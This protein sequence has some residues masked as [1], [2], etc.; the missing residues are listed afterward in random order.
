MVDMDI[1]VR[2]GNT[3]SVIWVVPEGFEAGPHVQVYNHNT[4]DT[5]TV[6]PIRALRWFFRKKQMWLA[7]IVGTILG[8]IIFWPI[9]FVMMV[10]PFLYFKRRALNAIKGMFASREFTQLQGQLSQVKPAA[11]AAA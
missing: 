1:A 8:F 2:E 4:G 7:T 6:N 11:A 9:G 5:T 10:G 3:V